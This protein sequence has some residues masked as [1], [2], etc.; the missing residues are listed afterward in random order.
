MG[1]TGR[2][3]RIGGFSGLG[4]NSNDGIMWTSFYEV[5]LYGINADQ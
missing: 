5:Y 2:I 3:Q 1:G 4:D